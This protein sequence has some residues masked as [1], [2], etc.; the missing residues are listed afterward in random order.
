MKAVILCGGQGSRIRDVSELMPKPMLPIGDRPILWHI[1]KSYAAHGIKDFV[2]CLGY[3]GW[4]IKEFFLHYRPMITDCTITLGRHT[5]VEYHHEIEEAN[6]R[7]T[8]VDTGENTMTG[9]RI[10]RIR[11]YVE[12]DEHFCVTYGDGVAD[13]NFRQ[14]IQTHQKSKL[15]G[16]LTGVRLAGRFGE[17]EYAKGKVAKFKEKPAV[18]MGRINGGFMI[19]DSKKVWKYFE[20]DDSLILERQPLEKMAKAAQLGIY[21]HDGYWQCMDTPREYTMLNDLWNSGKAPWKV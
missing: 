9:G 2:L 4:V 8:L 16:T 3:K 18:T 20:G 11:K 21:E 1:M 14:L 12:Q 13:I 17:L 6:W 15:A 5:E 10:R 19:F 7:V